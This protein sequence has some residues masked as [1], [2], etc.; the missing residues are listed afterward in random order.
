M[1]I[2]NLQRRSSGANLTYDKRV[3]IDHFGLDP[4]PNHV[5]VIFE[6]TD[7][8]DIF[9]QVLNSGEGFRS[10]MRLPFGAGSQRY[11]A[12]GINDTVL[13]YAFEESIVLDDSGEEFT[14]KFHLKY[15]VTDYRKVAET[16][17]MDPLRRLRDEVARV[18][19][20]NCA[21][22]KA[23][24]FRDR[25]RDLERI[26]ID[27]ESAK[28]RPYATELGFK[29]IS[30]D[31][32]KSSKDSPADRAMDTT[33]RLV[34]RDTLESAVQGV[35]AIQ[36]PERFREAFEVARSLELPGHPDDKSAHL[37]ALPGSEVES[38]DTRSQ[39]ED[40]GVV[41][42]PGRGDDN[43][44]SAHE[45]WQDQKECLRQLAETAGADEDKT[46]CLREGIEALE[47]EYFVPV[48]VR[49]ASLASPDNSVFDM[50]MCSVFTPPVLAPGANTL[51]QVF[52]HR[53]DEQQMVREAA[54]EF[55][56]EAK[57]LASTSLTQPAQQ[58]SVLKFLIVLPGLEID[59]P[60]QELTWRG[61]QESVQFGVHIPKDLEA[62]EIVGTIYMSQADVPFGHAKFVL[63][64]ATDEGTPQS[65]AGTVEKSS[66][67]E[68]I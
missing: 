38:K 46:R 43:S 55:D 11:F 35:A 1:S 18:I 47:A 25:F 39:P 66:F 23:E 42:S 63:R 19:G 10:R 14:L 58:S 60:V 41:T 9:N 17:D 65:S 59:D 16:R 28:L 12:I 4:L 68:T 29:I 32:D 53:I 45:M 5:L 50:V 2:L 7:R 44:K 3:T 57:R 37:P 67:V 22:R 24:M 36:T 61:H 62:Q 20:R 27:S 40:E 56:Y 64:V 13:S 21:K 30:I 52:A 15:R 34:Y 33:Q 48:P 6:R 54:A 26:V 51:V 49:E 31:L 8:G